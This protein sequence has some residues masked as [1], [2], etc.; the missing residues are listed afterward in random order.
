MPDTFTEQIETVSEH[1]QAADELAA[2]VIRRAEAAGLAVSSEV[3]REAVALMRRLVRSKL[4]PARLLSEFLD[5]FKAILRKYEP[6]LARVI[7]DSQIAGFLEGGHGVVR[8]IPELAESPLD[9]SMESIFGLKPPPP[10]WSK[11]GYG[12]GDAEPILKFPIIQE[13]A[14]DLARRGILT[15]EYFETQAGQARLEGLTLARV[16][17]LDALEKMRDALIDAVVDGDTL[18]MFRA[19]A[20]EAFDKSRLSPTRQEMLFRNHVMNAYARGQRAVVEQPLI[21]S[22]AMWAWRTEIDDSRLTDLCRVLSRSGLEN[23]RGQRTSIYFVEDEMW[24]RVAAPSHAGCRCGA[25][26]LTTKR[27]AENGVAVAKKWHETGVR[28]PDEE[29][30]VPFPD[31]SDVPLKE[32]EAFGSWQSPWA[33]AA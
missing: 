11:L 32:R 26:F 12:E 33:M 7:S 13:A 5:S 3:R 27:A 2:R 16:G 1:K 31:L 21:R 22:I 15:P 10:D 25:I 4:V 23:M 29:L 8:K 17:S 30:F 28:P 19:K 14:T 24:R 9:R 18:G 20:K 6:V